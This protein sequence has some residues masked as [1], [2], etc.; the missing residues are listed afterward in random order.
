[1][2][3]D[4]GDPSQA[5]ILET[6]RSLHP[7]DAPSF[8]TATRTRLDAISSGLEFSIDKLADSVHAISQYRD[9]VDTVVSQVLAGSARALEE[10]HRSEAAPDGPGTRDVLRGLSRVLER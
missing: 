8:E 7:P 9:A 1:L 10:R 3:T 6:L 4:L 5:S 2:P